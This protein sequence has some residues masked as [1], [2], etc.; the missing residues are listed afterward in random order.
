M[1]D[2]DEDYLERSQQRWRGDE[3]PQHLT[4][5]VMM[6]GEPFVEFLRPHARTVRTDTIA[7]IGPGYGRITEA[8]IKSDI[9]F[10]RYI[11]LEL[12]EARV[13]RLRSAFTDPR[14][15]FRQADIL[16]P[17][18]LNEP[19]ALVFA[20]GVFEHFYPD[21]RQ[22]L[23]SISSLLKSGGAV[24]FDLIREENGAPRPVWHDDG[25]YY[26]IYSIAEVAHQLREAGLTTEEVRPLSF[27]PNGYGTEVLRTAVCA[28]K[29]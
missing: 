2:E 13:D 28:R 12:S 10:G 18:A 23:R 22:A 27:G 9:P 17:V 21:L 19:F 29:S 1:A 4:W 8:V 3:E 16:G 5:G 6:S 15:E 26:R 25:T 24:V 14:I 11:G 7:E 20:S